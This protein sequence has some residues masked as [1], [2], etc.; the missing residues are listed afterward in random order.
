MRHRNQRTRLGKP[1]AHRTAMMR[2]LAIALIEH[3]R[4]H[5]TDAKA[6]ELKKFIDR[7]I[8]L[9]KEGTVQ[10]RRHAFSLLAQKESVHKLFEEI[11]PRYK[12]RSG[13]YSRVVKDAPRHGDAALMSYIE[14]TERVVK[15]VKPKKK[16]RER[17]VMPH[18]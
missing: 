3:E 13:G 8:T 12:E 5:T 7:L 9:G 2:N 11:A 17:P 4:I 15:E 1:T 14:L 16:K 18:F 6:K 10:A